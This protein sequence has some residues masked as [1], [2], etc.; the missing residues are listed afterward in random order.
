LLRTN[1]LANLAGSGWIAVLTLVATPVQIH[2]L[3]VEAFGLV[4]LIAI[5]QIAFATLDLGLSASVTQSIAADGSEGRRASAPLINSAATLYWA[6]ALGI[7]LLLWLTAGWIAARWLNPQALDHATVLAAVRTIGLY[8]AIRWPIAFYT[9]V[10]NGV[11]RMEVL[12]LLK[13]GAATLRIAVGIAVIVVT[14]DV[15]AFLAWFAVSAVVELIAFAIVTHRLVPALGFKPFFSLAAV[16]SVWRFSLT[17]AGIA[18]MAML[19]TQMDRL[20]VSKLL[21]LGAFGY[22]SLAYTTAIGISLLQVS[23]NTA[24]LPAFS[25]AAAQGGQGELR[26]RYGMASELM[27]Y[28]TAL[29]CCALIV[30]GADILRIW[31]G[32]DAARGASAAL[33][34]LAAGSFLNAA[35]SNAYIAA[36]ATRAAAIPAWVNAVG[37]LAY[38]PLL[39]WL[40]ARAGTS[41]AASGWVLLN[42]YYLFSLLPLV[43]GRVLGAPLGGW[44]WRCLALPA[45]VAI[46]AFVPL[47]AAAALAGS[48]ITTWVAL[49]LAILAYGLLSLAAMSR[50]LRDGLLDFGPIGAVASLAW[51]RAR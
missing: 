43:H 2:L 4:G 26:Q 51:R 11:Q 25:Q 42:L 8:V 5:L 27:A 40:T 1:I 47:K 41:G 44:L 13:A 31:V 36:V 24:S 49:A 17:M 9:G 33:A 29:P 10:L 14:R 21:S 15:V 48:G 34:L 3:G 22:Y 39:Y 38:A 30:F 50:N 35:V 45:L 46:A 28:V 32:D 19:L 16:R 18:V 12:N 20:F 23:I 37:I 7:G 6:M